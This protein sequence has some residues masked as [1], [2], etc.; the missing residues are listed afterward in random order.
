M[1]T[2]NAKLVVTRNNS[3]LKEIAVHS[4]HKHEAYVYLIG[5]HT[6]AL[7]IVRQLLAY[8]TITDPVMYVSRNLSLVIS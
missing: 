8:S 2:L 6:R 4:V 1:K 3:K 7:T 5:M